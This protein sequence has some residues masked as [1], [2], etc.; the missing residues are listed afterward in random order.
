MAYHVVSVPCRLVQSLCQ[1]VDA[2]V[3][4]PVVAGFQHQTEQLLIN[5]DKGRQDRPYAP[6]LGG[7]QNA[8]PTLDTHVHQLHV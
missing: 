8:T 2:T 4:K 7:P 1:A 6:L 3:N 5:A